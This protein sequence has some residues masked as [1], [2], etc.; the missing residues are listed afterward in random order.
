M[1]RRFLCNPLLGF[2]EHVIWTVLFCHSHTPGNR[3]A[4]VLFVVPL[5]SLHI[6]TFK[7]KVII[8]IKHVSMYTGCAHMIASV[9]TSRPI[10]LQ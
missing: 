10:A 7:A 3:S 8:Y 5:P 6:I 2:G 4:M 1:A 9:N